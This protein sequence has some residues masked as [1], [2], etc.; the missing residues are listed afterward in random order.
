[1]LRVQLRSL[2]TLLDNPEFIAPT[3][4]Q[5][6][7]PRNPGLG[8]SRCA[9]RMTLEGQSIEYVSSFSRQLA[10]LCDNF[11]ELVEAQN[12]PHDWKPPVPMR[13]RRPLVSVLPRSR[14]SLLST[15][16]LQHLLLPTA[17][18]LTRTLISGPI[19]LTTIVG[20]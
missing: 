16:Q 5:T 20:L 11:H 9:T 7:F 13:C 3:R 12:S 19:A 8:A 2:S 14:W 10:R 15:L 4:M 17:I 18:K 1:V 6:M